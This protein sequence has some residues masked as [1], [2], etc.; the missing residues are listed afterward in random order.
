MG[1]VIVIA[2]IATF[3]II[4]VS[5]KVVVICGDAGEIGGVLCSR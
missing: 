3:A 4:L 5:L 2:S 1:F